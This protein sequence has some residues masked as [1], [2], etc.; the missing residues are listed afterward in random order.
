MIYSF[1][2]INFFGKMVF[3]PTKNNKFS[4]CELQPADI[5]AQSTF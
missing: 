1:F 4:E 3:S 2:N 5:I